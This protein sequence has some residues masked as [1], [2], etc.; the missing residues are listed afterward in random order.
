[1]TQSHESLSVD[2][3]H[4]PEGRHIPDVPL[5]THIN[6]TPFPSQ[7]FQTVDQHAEVFHVVVTRITYDLRQ[8]WGQDFLSYAEEQSPLAISDEWD[9][10][11]NE[12]SPLWESDFAPYKPKCDI[13]VANAVSRPHASSQPR[14][15][16]L[17]ARRWICGLG[18]RWTTPDRESRQ[19]EKQIVVTGER[20]YGIFGCG[21]PSPASEVRIHWQNASGGN[22]ASSDGMAIDKT[23]WRNPIGVGIDQRSGKRA[24]QLEI[25]AAH[26]YQSQ[27]NYPPISLSALGRAWL[28]RRVLAGTYD[29][30]WLD[31]QWPLPPMNFD[32][33]YWNGAPADQQTDYPTP[34]TRFDL[35][36]LY[37]IDINQEWCEH[38]TARLPL[39]QLFVHFYDESAP[40]LGSDCLADLDTVVFDMS[41]LQL[42]ASYRVVVSALDQ[43]PEAKIVFETRMAP[44]G[45][46][47]ESIPSSELG[48]LG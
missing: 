40:A 47:R 39:H 45:S 34:G 30:D 42:Y 8:L 31:N 20:T 11:V 16:S 43:T 24:P 9:G 44:V 26:P 28:P 12:S 22:I 17:K 38:F 5:A 13:L 32:Y 15:D 41:K 33:A 27:E 25:S 6:H 19:W 7:Y 23:D 35:L 14:D 3:M 1:M 10:E 4:E 36:G 18:M 48:P 21:A 29:K 37:P 2:A 46:M